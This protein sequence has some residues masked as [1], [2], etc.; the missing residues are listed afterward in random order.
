V[1]HT[2]PYCKDGVPHGCEAASFR[3]AP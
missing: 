3:T 2:L 1:R